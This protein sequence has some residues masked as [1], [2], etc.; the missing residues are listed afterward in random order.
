MSITKEVKMTL[1]KNSNNITKEVKMTLFKNSNNNNNNNITKEVKMT[2]K[3]KF[4]YFIFM[5]F[6]IASSA[7]LAIANLASPC[8]KMRPP[9]QG[10]ESIQDL[11]GQDL[12]CM[13]LRNVHFHQNVDLSNTNLTGALL[14]KETLIDADLT[15][16]NLTDG[17]LSWANLTNAD[18]TRANLTEADL[19]K[20]TFTKLMQILSEKLQVT[21]EGVSKAIIRKLDEALR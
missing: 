7:N 9:M 18:L 14:R 20:V 15:G 8:E 3:T 17:N 6:F 4:S 5:L 10:I 1:F 2:L 13:D 21:P 16:A 12:S 11:S 19:E